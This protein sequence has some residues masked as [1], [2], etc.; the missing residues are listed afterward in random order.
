VLGQA[1]T[2]KTPSTT[3]LVVFGQFVGALGTCRGARDWQLLGVGYL[4]NAQVI[5]SG[6]G[7]ALIEFTGDLPH[8]QD[9]RHELQIRA[10]R[11]GLAGW[12]G[13]RP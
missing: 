10:A 1:T 4:S 2:C 7:L 9:Y 6:R 5:P 11:R 8:F 3:S 13:G 12:F